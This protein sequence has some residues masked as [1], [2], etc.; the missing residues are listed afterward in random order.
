MA[1]RVR[2]EAR[3]RVFLS[4]VEVPGGSQ[5]AAAQPAAP[6]PPPGAIVQTVSIGWSDVDGTHLGRRR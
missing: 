5:P 3:R 6:A 2:G 4:P 1:A